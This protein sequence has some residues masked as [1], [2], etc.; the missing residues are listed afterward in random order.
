MND[1][2]CFDHC[3]NHLLWRKV[4]LGDLLGESP[5]NSEIVIVQSSTNDNLE[6]IKSN[7]VV[8]TSFNRFSYFFWGVILLTILFIKIQ[9]EL[10]FVIISWCTKHR[11][12]SNELDNLSDDVSYKSN[13][14][15]LLNALSGLEV[16][17][18]QPLDEEEGFSIPIKKA[19]PNDPLVGLE[20][21]N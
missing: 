8:W 19:S 14:H 5:G 16:V 6:G 11:S 13:H 18:R 2:S 4:V 15:H 21:L 7:I 9:D 12:R 1:L 17:L 20:F 3:S 10:R